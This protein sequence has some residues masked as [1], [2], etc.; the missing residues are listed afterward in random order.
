MSNDAGSVSSDEQH[1]RVGASETAAHLETESLEQRSWEQLELAREALA[2]SSDRLA[3]SEAALRR[4]A[5]RLKRDQAD[6][7]REMAVS[8]L[9][10]KIAQRESAD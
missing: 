1:V 5:A 3:R 7:D 10:M 2:R 4:T 9:D 8:E 6:N